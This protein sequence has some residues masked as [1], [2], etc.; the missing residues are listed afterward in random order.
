[1]TDG[2]EL[3][4]YLDGFLEMSS[5]PVLGKVEQRIRYD[6]WKSFSGEQDLKDTRNCTDFPHEACETGYGTKSLVSCLRSWVWV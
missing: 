2:K 4:T 5:D 3:L 1:M 6:L